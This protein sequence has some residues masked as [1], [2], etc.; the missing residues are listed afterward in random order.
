MT[1]LP[2]PLPKD[3]AAVTPAVAPGLPDL[4]DLPPPVG[5]NEPDAGAVLARV[6][7]AIV[8]FRW[9]VLAVILLGSAASVVATR[10]LRPEYAVGATIWI[11]RS[12][13]QRGPI[14]P[15][16]LLSTRNWQELL[17][18]FVVLDPV[19]LKQRLYLV[20][21]ST[22]DLPLF[23]D[24]SL[25]PRFAPAQYVLEVDP[26]AR[27]YSL[28]TKTGLFSEQGKLG[29]SIGR[30]PGL[31]WAP[32]ASRFTAARKVEFTLLTPREASS[33]LAIRLTTALREQG[34]FLRLT[35]TGEDPQRTAS[36]MNNLASRFAEVA[37][38]LQK[39]N[40][41]KLRLALEE[42]VGQSEGSLRDAEREL[43]SYRVRTITLPGETALSITP[44]LMST[45][46]PA[47]GQYFQQKTQLDEIRRD[48]R[49]VEDVLKKAEGGE[50]AVDAF[51][52]IHH[53]REAPDLSRVLQ[54]LS[55]TEAERRLLLQKYTPE[56]KGVKE[57]DDKV[58]GLRRRVIPAYAVALVDRLKSMESDLEVRI[59]G[60]DRELREIPIRT[61]NEER[62]RRDV[63]GKRVIFTNLQARY[64]EAKLAEL[65]VVPEVTIFDTA[66]A[67]TRPSRNT[68]P[69]ILLLGLTAS[70]GLALALALLLD[71]VDPRFRYPEQATNDLGLTI[72]GAIPEIKHHRNGRGD[73][74]GV[75]QVIEAFRSI[76][77]NLAH[78]FDASG[79]LVFTITSPGPGDGKSLVST[80]LSLS[81]A[82]AGYRTL[83]IDGDTR[84]GELHRMFQVD[85]RPGLLDHLGAQASLEEV[86]RPTTHEHLTLIPCG[87]RRSQGPELLG[88]ATMAQ[89][90]TAVRSRFD[91]IVIDSPPLGAGIDP[92]VLGT[93]SGHMLMVLRAGQTDRAMA[94]SRLKIVDR[95][96]IRMLG[97]VLNDFSSTGGVYKYYSYLSG[98]ASEEEVAAEEQSQITAPAKGT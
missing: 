26:V 28:K 86:L 14:R 95:L 9:L 51:Q 58:E 54:E 73:P 59:S 5:D 1:R 87:S 80:N 91:V 97:A 16:E 8:R 79:P 27:T 35:L 15:D 53:V 56:Y 75:H 68:A 98:Y 78:S 90:I 22:K 32:P 60:A 10:I 20:P 6:R 89:L 34:E 31:R 25:G 92:F 17:T 61:M 49:A 24:F 93:L 13:N 57:L 19:V 45:Q 48:R 29:D 36:T 88:S 52:T 2:A 23:E 70:L 46:A 65:S 62:F 83:L 18:T 50:L 42:Q 44:G 67:P 96:P 66:V 7:A 63:E 82:Q 41:K 77:L 69:R 33:D 64:E 74:E 11:N 43:E 81:F 94:E 39:D 4:P 21:H 72:L 30:G 12:N 3:E 40:L 84:R 85:R 76:R 38:E 71:R 37:G 47:L 55:T